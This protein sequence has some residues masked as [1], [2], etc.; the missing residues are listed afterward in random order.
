MKF[1]P[2][3][4]SDSEPYSPALVE[5]ATRAEADAQFSVG[6]C[7]ANGAG[8]EKD[9]QEAVRWYRKAAEQGHP[10]AQCNLGLCLGR[11][12]GV[13]QDY[14]E[15]SCWLHKAA[16]QCDALAQRSLGIA[17][18]NGLGVGQDHL[19]AAKWFRKAARQGNAEAQCDLAVC[20]ENGQGVRMNK[21]EA[22]RLRRLATH[23]FVN[24]ICQLCGC[25]E[26]AVKR[27][28]WSCGKE[29]V[30]NPK[31]KGHDD[32]VAGHKFANGVCKLCGCSEAAVNSFGWSCGKE[33]RFKQ[34]ATP[35]GSEHSPAFSLLDVFFPFPKIAKV[36][37]D[38]F[39]LKENPAIFV[40]GRRLAN[41]YKLVRLLGRGGMGVVWLAK[42]EKLER[43]VALKFLPEGVISDPL[44]LKSLKRET[45]RCLNLTHRNIVRVHDLVQDESH[46]LTF[47]SMEFVDGDNLSNLRANRTHGC[48]E[49]DELFDFVGQLC[50]GLIY[51]HEHVQII[52]RD[53]KPGNLMVNNRNELKIADFGIARSLVDAMS[54]VTGSQDTISGTLPYMSPQ[55]VVGEP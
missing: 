48:F 4:T 23:K 36:A 44:A 9:E 2:L 43:D 26:A 22:A 33:S 42:D 47:I 6:V 24:E 28:G 35:T 14:V 19:E 1:H 31:S 18:S 55:Q 10:L 54:R 25:N 34:K 5:R 40:A 30:T 12:S 45:N 46:S 21:R 13:A 3:N 7:Y 17:Y 50:D 49:V 27:F 39:K 41:R 16:E 51:A 15:A 8:V 52:H 38:Y 37:K 20:Y 11:G 29:S 32:R 53:L